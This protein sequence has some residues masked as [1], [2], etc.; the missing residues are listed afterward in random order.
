MHSRQI[1]VFHKRHKN[2]QRENQFCAHIVEA[3][4]A[5]LVPTAFVIDPTLTHCPVDSR[6]IVRWLKADQLLPCRQRQECIKRLLDLPKRIVVFG[7]R[8][9]S[10]DF[11][12][13]R[14]NERYYW[15]FHEQQHFKLTDPRLRVVYAEDGSKYPVPR[16]LQR[17]LRDVWRVNNF[18]DFTIVWHDWF[19]ENCDSYV[20]ALGP[21][22]QE[23]HR[24]GAFSFRTFCTL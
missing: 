13:Q 22:F 14:E 17:L 23:H 8:P 10:F 21:G 24:P 4:G 11:V 18:P 12:V 16:Y 15:E 19:A 5:E 6:Q 20:P 2:Q 3:W 1:K 9:I 7:S